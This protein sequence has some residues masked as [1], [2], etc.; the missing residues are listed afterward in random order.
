[1]VV[2]EFKQN[3]NSNPMKVLARFEPRQKRIL[4]VGLAIVLIAGI[5]FFV[6]LPLVDKNLRLHQSV[7]AQREL[8]TWMEKTTKDVRGIR[9]SSTLEGTLHSSGSL[10]SLV[11]VATR[12]IDLD[13]YLR[14]MQPNGETQVTVS[15]D[16][17]PFDT[18]I[19]WF[20]MLTL[21][22]GIEVVEVVLTRSATPGL[23]EA[24]VVLT[25]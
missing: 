25:R 5:T 13:R 19:G 22:H 24:R 8:L 12:E 15:L 16:A 21:E 9:G 4:L 11:S 1:M 18:V 6:W 3:L 14:Q 2:Y 23:V 7:T 20:Q 17:A 10:M